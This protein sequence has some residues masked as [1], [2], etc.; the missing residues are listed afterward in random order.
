MCIYDQAYT[1]MCILEGLHKFYFFKSN[2][3]IKI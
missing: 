3:L 2:Y 1:N